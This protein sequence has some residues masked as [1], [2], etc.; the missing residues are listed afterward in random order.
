MNSQFSM[1]TTMCRFS[2][3][4]A[5][6]N[7]SP[8]ISCA[9]GQCESYILLLLNVGLYRVPATVPVVLISPNVITGQEGNEEVQELHREIPEIESIST[10]EHEQLSD[11]FSSANASPK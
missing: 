3:D 1:A 10:S 11:T 9:C 8:G 2:A 4:W 7:L 6:V 5:V